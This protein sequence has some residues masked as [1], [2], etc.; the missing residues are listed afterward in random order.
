MKN[1]TASMLAIGDELLSGRTKDKNISW[2]ADQLPPL[3]IDLEE[4]RIIPDNQEKIMSSVRHLKAHT[5]MLFTSGG[6]GP[7]HDD[8]TAEAISKAFGEAF[9][10]RE[11]AE[12]VLRAFHG[13]GISD[14]ILRMARVPKSSIL[15]PNPV[16]G[17]PGFS[18]WNVHVMAGVPKIF[19]AMFNEIKDDLPRGQIPIEATIKI[20]I[21]ESKVSKDLRYIAS[22]FP[23]LSIGS[24]PFQ[25][26]GKYG[27][28]IVVKG[29]EGGRVE[30]IEKILLQKYGSWLSPESVKKYETFQ[31]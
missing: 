7:T 17:A 24:Y 28:R 6:L 4:V 29:K 12:Q 1:P 2:L 8:I 26:Q 13:E 15:I 10:A 3:G 25:E 19:Q 18:L 14:E 23:D 31:S 30:E 16:S 5:D 27:A 20:Y 21:P 22:S 11:D 9:I